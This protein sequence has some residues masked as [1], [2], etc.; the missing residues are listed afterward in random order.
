MILKSLLDVLFR[1]EI[2]KCHR[3]ESLVK[4]DIVFFGENLPSRFYD[5]IPSVRSLY[6][7]VSRGYSIKLGFREM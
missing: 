5:L 2:P 3:C 6:N 7:N 1:D 4:P